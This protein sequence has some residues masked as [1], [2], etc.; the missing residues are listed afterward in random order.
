MTGAPSPSSRSSHGASRPFCTQ[1]T[2]Q[3]RSSPLS[4]VG[5][6]IVALRRDDATLL[7]GWSYLDLGFSRL[8]TP[9]FF[10]LERHGPLSQS[11]KSP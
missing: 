7:L 6:P 4:R 1:R 8:G 3:P 2:F 5:D 9:V 10:S 11:A